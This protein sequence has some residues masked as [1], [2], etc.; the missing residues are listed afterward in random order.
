MVTNDILRT[1]VFLRRNNSVA[2]KFSIHPPIS[3]VHNRLFTRHRTLFSIIITQGSS[4]QISA[5][6]VETTVKALSQ[7]LSGNHTDSRIQ[8]EIRNYK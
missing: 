1:L 3:I 5:Y 4:S 8:Q 6:D 7:Y 2:F